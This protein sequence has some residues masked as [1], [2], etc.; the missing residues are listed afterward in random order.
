MQSSIDGGIISRV[1]M[2][3]DHRGFTYIFRKENKIT[4]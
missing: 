3:S 1:L 2:G 4:I